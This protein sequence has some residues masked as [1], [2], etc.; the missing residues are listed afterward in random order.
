M[1]RCLHVSLCLRPPLSLPPP[2]THTLGFTDAG[3]IQH[4]LQKYVVAGEDVHLITMAEK[5]QNVTAG[6]LK[7]QEKESLR[8]KWLQRNRLWM[9]K[10]KEVRP[11]S[12]SVWRLSGGYN[13]GVW[14]AYK[15]MQR[16][17]SFCWQVMI[18]FVSG[19]FVIFM[20]CL[21]SAN[22]AMFVAR[23]SPMLTLASL[24]VVFSHENG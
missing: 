12:T 18:C 19:G 13:W 3:N 21:R 8:Q 22:L 14:R 23:I 20:K 10:K 15:V 11:G 17:L 6:Q 24:C 16:L 7:R 9:I 4:T 2:S 1:V 5:M